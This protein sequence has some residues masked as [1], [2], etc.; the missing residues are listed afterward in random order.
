MALPAKKNRD[1]Q[2]L[3][4]DRNEGQDS[5][6]VLTGTEARQGTGP[7]SMV[8]V[9]AVSTIVALIVGYSITYYFTSSSPELQETRPE[10]GG[11]PIIPGK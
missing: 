11:P 7:R 10:T 9:V 6:I 5:Q 2:K 1:E 3:A 8:I 4:A